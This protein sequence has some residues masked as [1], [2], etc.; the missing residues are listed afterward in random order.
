MRRNHIVSQLPLRRRAAA[1]IEIVL[2]LGVSLP[3]VGILFMGGLRGCRN[4]WHVIANAV[5]MPYL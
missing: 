1:T 3:F 4:L 2:A 5:G